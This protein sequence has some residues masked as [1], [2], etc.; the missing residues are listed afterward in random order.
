MILLYHS[1]DFH[2]CGHLTSVNR[3][4]RSRFGQMYLPR[5]LPSGHW[6]L[7]MVWPH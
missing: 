2:T 1:L 4:V 3:S 5:C 7:Q 6:K